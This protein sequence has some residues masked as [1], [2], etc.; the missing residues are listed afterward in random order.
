M[1]TPD[2]YESQRCACAYLAADGTYLIRG[3]TYPLREALKANGATWDAERKQWTCP[4]TAVKA[5]LAH[6]MLVMI[7]VRVPAHCHEEA[8]ITYATH[9]EVQSG[10]MRLGCGWCDTPARC[11]EVVKIEEIIDLAAAELAVYNKEQNDDKQ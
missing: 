2:P 6:G 11:G 1:T 8:K 7:K 4:A 3:K 9:K 10:A 5:L